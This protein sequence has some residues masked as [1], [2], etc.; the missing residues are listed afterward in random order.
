MSTVDEVVHRMVTM[1]GAP[2]DVRKL[3]DGLRKSDKQ[4]AKMRPALLEALLSGAV[5]AETHTAGYVYVLAAVAGEANSTLNHAKF[6]QA[7]AAVF[8][9]GSPEQAAAVPAQLSV[10]ARQVAVSAAKVGPA[11]SVYS[12]QGLRRAVLLLQ[13]GNPDQ[14]TAAHA[15]LFLCSVRARNFGLAAPLAARVAYSVQAKDD[16]FVILDYLLY[17]YYGGVVAAAG[18]DYPR[19]VELFLLALTAPS[20]SISAVQVAAFKKYVLCSIIATGPMAQPAELPRD[21]TS[22]AVQRGV[23]RYCRDYVSLASAAAGKASRFY[24]A[25]YQRAAPLTHDGNMGLAKLAADRLVRFRIA[26]LTNTYV[27]L[28]LEEMA[29]VAELASADEAERYVREMIEDGDVNAT[30]S[31]RDGMV[32]FTGGGVAS[33]AE[34]MTD[35]MDARIREVAAVNALLKEK[36]IVLGLD[37]NYV[38]QQIRAEQEAAAGIGGDFGGDM[39]ADFGVGAG[40]G[41][42][43]DADMER[44]M[45]LSMQ[46]Q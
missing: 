1:S 42:G 32:S 23:A 16:G 3:V 8:L 13:R 39:P 40:V 29:R 36:N 5:A 18:R 31:Q 28:P 20:R 27:T 33:S 46:D 9:V 4:L 21:I 25:M 10:V 30:I 17:A 26:Q 7:A 15:P 24:E 43:G 14:V 11:W 19:A 45:M 22:S 35:A 41:A 38:K 44:A 6:L 2:G 34:E 12:I 37:K